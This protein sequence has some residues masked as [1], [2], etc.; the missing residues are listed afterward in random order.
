MAPTDPPAPP[1]PSAPLTGTL[2]VAGA[3]GMAG[4][5]V[6]RA[7][8]AAWPALRVRGA[9][10][11]TAPFYQHERLA[12]VQADLTRR[13][14]VRPALAGCDWAVL[15]AAN[16][17]GAGEAAAAPER[18]LTDNLVMDA[19]LLEACRAAGVRR[20]VYVS[21]ATVY[22]PFAG[23]I[24]E[25]ALDWNAE[26]HPAYAGVAWA[27]RAAEKLC[28]FWHGAG[29]MPIVILRAANLYGPYMKFDPARSNFIPALIRK[30]VDGLDP[31]EV[32]GRPEVT[33]DVLHADDFARAVLLGLARTD[34]AFDTFNLGSGERTTVGEVVEWVTRFSGHRPREI[35][36]RE[37]RPTS[38][39]FRALACDKIRRTL[40]WT[41]EIPA[42]EGVRRCVEW[43]KENR[44]WWTR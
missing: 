38:I 25:D 27:K 6:V 1:A 10:C 33:R 43:W 16:T 17:G 34:L 30:A 26:P 28:A 12:W 13:E 21:S 5:S 3:T 39:A 22:P 41:P 11:R 42:Q 31:F 14:E 9:W 20:A 8:L 2:F 15:T 29:R 23:A 7:A 18:Q 19:L 44:G 37:D 24:A 35:V 32:W 36:Y 40:G 4:S